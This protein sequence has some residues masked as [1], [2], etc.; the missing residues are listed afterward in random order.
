M[1]DNDVTCS[2]ELNMYKDIIN[3]SLK[4]VF[5][6]VEIMLR[7]F[8]SLMIYNA[9]GERYFYKLKLIKNRLCFVV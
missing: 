3:N 5:P 4:S 1:F 6:N 7:M 2:N 9:T 8:L